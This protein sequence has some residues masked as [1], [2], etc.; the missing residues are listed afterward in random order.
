MAR[1][2][3]GWGATEGPRKDNVA[4]EA[5]LNHKYIKRRRSRRRAHLRNIFVLIILHVK[6]I[7]GIK[8]F[9]TIGSNASFYLLEYPFLCTYLLLDTS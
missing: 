2:Q 8:F 4:L 5:L 1:K 6:I 7:A 9:D 3:D